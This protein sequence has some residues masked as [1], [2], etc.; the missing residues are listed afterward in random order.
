MWSHVE[1][2]NLAAPVLDDE[3]AVEQLERHRR[4]GEEIK[5]DDH[6]AVILEKGTPAVT[7]VGTAPR[8][9][10]VPSHRSFRD[11]QAEFLQFAMDLGGSP[12]R[13]LVR[14]PSDQ[15]TNLFRDLRST[16]LGPG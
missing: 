3:K 14:Q 15:S 8:A 5:R 1:V 12:V 4:H 16:T 7:C 2:Q 13:V 11:D 6:L 10:Q 9:S